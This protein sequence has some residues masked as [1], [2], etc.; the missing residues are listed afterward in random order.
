[1]S[2]DRVVFVYGVQTIEEDFEQNLV[3]Y[4]IRENFGIRDIN[5]ENGEEILT[6]L[7][8]LKEKGYKFILDRD[9]AGETLPVPQ[10]LRQKLTETLGL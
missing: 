7:K 1:M 6:H 10:C 4:A 3:E 8:Q 9:Y 2:E 5:I